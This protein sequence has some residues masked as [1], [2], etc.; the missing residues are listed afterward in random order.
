[1][2]QE[3]ALEIC[4]VFISREANSTDDLIKMIIDYDIENNLD[5]KVNEINVYVEEIADFNIEDI[6]ESMMFNVIAKLTDTVIIHSTDAK[7]I[8]GKEDNIVS[9]ITITKT[10]DAFLKKLITKAKVGNREDTFAKELKVK[11]LFT[12]ELISF[13]TLLILKKNKVI[14][15]RGIKLISNASIIS[16]LLNEVENQT[17]EFKQ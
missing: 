1:M 4:R 3:I 6:P 10:L 11:L 16:E 8:A 2:N 5:G 12:K 9:F 7:A 14:E 15:D 13:F 17:A